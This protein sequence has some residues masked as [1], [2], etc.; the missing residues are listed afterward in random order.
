MG[1]R[2]GLGPKLVLETRAGQVEARGHVR[3]RDV[4]R[5]LVNREA[6]GEAAPGRRVVPEGA[7]VVRRRRRREE[8]AQEVETGV[9]CRTV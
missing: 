7:A 1:T 9:R 3:I 8:G 5:A 2:L 4:D 6:H